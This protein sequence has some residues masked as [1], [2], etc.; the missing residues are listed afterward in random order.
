LLDQTALDELFPLCMEHRIRVI[1]GGP[2]NSGI[3][4]T[5]AVP[6][7]RFDYAPASTL[8]LERVRRI[9]AICARHDAPLAAVALQFPFAHDAVVAVIPGARSKADVL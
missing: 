2:F 7:A 1:I 8:T 6:G 9:E 3:L 4:A 5:G